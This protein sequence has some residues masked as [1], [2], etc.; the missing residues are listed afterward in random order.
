MTREHSRGKDLVAMNHEI[1]SSRTIQSSCSAPSISRRDLLKGVGSCVNAAALFS[2]I[3]VA[4]VTQAKGTA[5][6]PQV[7]DVFVFFTGSKKGNVVSLSDLVV[8]AP[9][10]IARAKDPASGEMRDHKGYSGMVLLLRVKPETVPPELQDSSAQGVLAYSGWCTHLGCLVELWDAEKKVFQC[11]CH[12]SAYDPLLGGKVMLGPAPRPL[13]ILPL[14]IE[15]NLLVVA[16][17]FSA[18]V[19]PQRN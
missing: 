16:A 13:P 2:I 4:T 9:P 6:P 12:K 1:E 8:D 7:G 19:G 5:E 15:E 18:R 14:K 11:P 10:V 3:G 17:E